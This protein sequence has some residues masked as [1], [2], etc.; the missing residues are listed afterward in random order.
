M[1]Q[2][3]SAAGI[4]SSGHLSPGSAPKPAMIATSILFRGLPPDAVLDIALA[5]KL[6]RVA[7]GSTVF[8]QGAPA[9]RLFV[10]LQGRVKAIQSAPDGQQVTARFLNPGDPFG[11]VVLIAAGT[12]PVTVL[13]EVDSFIAGWDAALM[14][15]FA[16]QYPKIAMNALQYVGAQLRDTQSRLQEAITERIEQRIAHAL[17]RLI[18]QSGRKTAEGIEINFPIS[19]QDIA[20]IT[21][22]RLF[23]VSR[24]LSKWQSEGI[25]KGGRRRIMVVAP[26]RLVMIAEKSSRDPA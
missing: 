22:S 6:K 1:V 17:L 8:E 19:R 21:G 26:H 4:G 18:G 5:G 15:R 13:A 2:V 14:V 12:Y 23:T 3:L 24:T 10:L 20:E 9:N 7:K 16:D 11:C 25:I